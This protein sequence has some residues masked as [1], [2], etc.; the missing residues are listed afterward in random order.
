MRF[1]L[2]PVFAYERLIVARRWQTYAARSFVVATLL[3]AMALVA[4]SNA[5]RDPRNT[6]QAAAELGRYYFYALTG[7][8]LALVM[9]VAPTATAGAICLDRAR[10]NAGAHLGDRSVGFGGRPG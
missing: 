7:V 10:G 4:S 3:F 8:E 2:G 5:R 1:G 9:L 6:V